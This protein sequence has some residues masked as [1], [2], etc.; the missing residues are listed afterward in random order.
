MNIV[1]HPMYAPR[2][3]RWSR[4]SHRGPR[5]HLIAMVAST[6]R[7]FLRHS[8]RNREKN[9]FQQGVWGT[10]VR[11]GAEFEQNSQSG[12]SQ[13]DPHQNSEP[14]RSFRCRLPDYEVQHGLKRVDPLRQRLMVYAHDFRNDC[15]GV[16][17]VAHVLDFSTP[18]L[19]STEDSDSNRSGVAINTE[20]M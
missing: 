14:F 4:N 18:L 11:L 20:G 16:G 6:G 15:G 10:P 2:D 8:C 9:K 1:L 19:R 13:P 7:T 5:T 17:K 3:P 12:H